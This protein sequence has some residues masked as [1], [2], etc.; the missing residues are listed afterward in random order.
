M[1]A[2]NEKKAQDA[3]ERLNKEG[4]GPRNGEVLWL[5]LDLSD[6]RKAKKSAEELLRKEKRLDVV[7]K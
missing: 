6:P 3:I 5:D 1:G 7:G 2:R 4:R